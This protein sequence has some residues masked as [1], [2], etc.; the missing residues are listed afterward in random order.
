MR[1]KGENAVDK[2]KKGGRKA[3]PPAR[4]ETAAEVAD[5]V[6]VENLVVG[7]EKQAMFRRGGLGLACARL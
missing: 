4:A 3:L 1:G 7:E 2:P 6:V 5:A